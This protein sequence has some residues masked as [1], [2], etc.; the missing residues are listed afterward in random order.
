[1]H[2]EAN[3]RFLAILRTRLKIDLCGGVCGTPASYQEGPR[4]KDRFKYVFKGVSHSL[5][6]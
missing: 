6:K 4:Y 3:S 1:M 5:S 2:D